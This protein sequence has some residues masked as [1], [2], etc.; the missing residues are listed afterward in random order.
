MPAICIVVFYLCPCVGVVLVCTGLKSGNDRLWQIGLC[1]ASPLIAI[2]G[3]MVVVV[4]LGFMM[5]L[6]KDIWWGIRCQ[7][8]DDSLIQKTL[9]Q[10]LCNSLYLIFM[11]CTMIGVVLGYTGMIFGNDQLWLIGVWLAG[12]AIVIAIVIFAIL[13]T[14]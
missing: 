1:F 11:I 2:I 3:L 9:K 6:C 4:L 8:F 13:P 14:V 10:T 7:L 5:E 12:P